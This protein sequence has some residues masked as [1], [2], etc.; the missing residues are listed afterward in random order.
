MK[1]YETAC[2]ETEEKIAKLK[3]Q[4]KRFSATLDE[5]TSLKNVRYLNV[6]VHYTNES[7][8]LDHINLGLIR[9]LDTL[10]AEKLKE[11]VSS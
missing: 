3:S 5:W 9:I 2:T 4:G 6:N 7:G 8:E 10:P 11:E 1:F